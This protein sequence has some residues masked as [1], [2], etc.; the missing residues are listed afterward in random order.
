MAPLAV[1]S[2]AS[3]ASVTYGNSIN[4]TATATGGTPGT[5]Q[6]AL[7]R[8]L[9]GTSTWIPNPLVWQAGNVLGWTPTSADVGTWQMAVA[10]RDV[11]TAPGANG[12]GYSAYTLPGTDQVVAPIT[13]SVTS[14]PASS[15]YGNA[16]TWTATANGGIPAS[17][18]YA[19]FRRRAGATPGF[20]MPRP[21]PGRPAT[22]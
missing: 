8:Q 13:L 12:Y 21:L 3:P 2:T 1:T 14:S 10:V 19:L 5:V 6:Y 7:A 9:V 4:W 15:V 16:I 11:N 20:L 22:S 17:T 18:K